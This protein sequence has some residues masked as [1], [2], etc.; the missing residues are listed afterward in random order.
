M[1]QALIHGLFVL[2]AVGIAVVEHV[3]QSAYARARPH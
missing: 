2:S 1:W 3:S